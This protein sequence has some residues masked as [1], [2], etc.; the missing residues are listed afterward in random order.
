M[1]TFSYLHKWSFPV[2]VF[3]YLHTLASSRDHVR[4]WQSCKQPASPAFIRGFKS[5]TDLAGTVHS[6]DAIAELPKMLN[7]WLRGWLWT[8]SSRLLWDSPLFMSKTR[9]VQSRDD[10]MQGT[11]ATVS[12]RMQQICHIQCFTQSPNPFLFLEFSEPWRRCYRCSIMASYSI[13]L[14]FSV[15]WPVMCLFSHC[16]PL[17]TEASLTTAYS[18]TILWAQTVI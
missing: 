14:F 3:P 15:L 6:H 5:R 1:I 4:L 18:S 9:L 17:Q 16:W 10:L 13:S 7:T 12:S 2:L 8:Q 11:V